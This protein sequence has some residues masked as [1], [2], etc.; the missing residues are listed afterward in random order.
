MS[1]P[2]R[3]RLA[4]LAA[5]ASQAL[6]TAAAAQTPELA[7]EFPGRI[8][9]AHNTVRAQAGVAPL[10]WDNEL[11]R[12][13]AAYALRLAITNTF[14][15]SD[16]SARAGTGENLWMG[17]RGAYNFEQMV[18]GWSS[19]RRWFAPGIFPAVSRSGNWEDVGHYTQM[20]WPTTTR[21]GC[22][23]ATNASH[24]FLVCR[25]SPAGNVDGHA[26]LTTAAANLGFAQP[27]YRR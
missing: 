16:R 14:Q 18:G 24:D 26:V 3:L 12:Q 2:F 11:G 13:A 7:R 9:A 4:A 10:T 25:Y 19:E 22:A 21:V 6:V 8:L 1:K 23:M 15:H 5:I 27:R 20:V 17:S